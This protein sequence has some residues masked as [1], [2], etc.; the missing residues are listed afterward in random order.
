MKP[1][2]GRSTST[3]RRRMIV[4]HGGKLIPVL[5][6]AP[7]VKIKVEAGRS[8]RAM[9]R[10]RNH[11]GRKKSPVP[12]PAAIKSPVSLSVRKAPGT[13]ASDRGGEGG[14]GAG[15]WGGGGRGGGGGGGGGGG[16]GG[17][18]GGGI[19]PKR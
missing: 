18:G 17:G 11:A 2:E 16:W 6:T 10:A 3:H 9:L 8:P 19:K 14:G 12:P 5:S 1:K 13:Q 15:G 7:E 4:G